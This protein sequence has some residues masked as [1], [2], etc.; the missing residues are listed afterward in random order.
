MANEKWKAIKWIII[1]VLGLGILAL[2]L[3]SGVE[4]TE[5]SG[6]FGL[7]GLGTGG[8]LLG[9]LTKRSR[10][11]S[12]GSDNRTTGERLD[13]VSDELEG[14]SGVVTTVSEGIE[15]VEIRVSGSVESSGQVADRIRDNLASGKYTIRDS[16][17]NILRPTD[18]PHPQS[19]PLEGQ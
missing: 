8:G 14:I 18:S 11:A 3:F 5:G 16:S 10:D 15:S 6:I 2:L 13:D 7:L 1:A 9:G 4:F 17:G 12:G 19:D